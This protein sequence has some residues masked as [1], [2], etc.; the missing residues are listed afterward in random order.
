M[1]HT[2]DATRP[3]LTNDPE[4]DVR[5]HVTKR[6]INGGRSNAIAATHSLDWRTPAN[7]PAF[8][9]YLGDR[10]RISGQP[11]PVRCRSHPA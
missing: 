2:Y 6:K 9:D 1:V 3:L 11:N 7:S 4:R 10:L 5:L 8:W